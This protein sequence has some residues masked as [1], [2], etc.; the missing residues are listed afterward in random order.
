MHDVSI[1]KLTKEHPGN[2]PKE[3]EAANVRNVIKLKQ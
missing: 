2:D 1:K 3:E